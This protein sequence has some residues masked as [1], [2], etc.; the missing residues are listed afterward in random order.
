MRLLLLTL[1]LFLFNLTQNYS[2][3]KDSSCQNISV[4]SY[5][6]QGDFTAGITAGY[7]FK[8]QVPSYGL[9][10]D[11][12][13]HQLKIGLISIG[14]TGK[15]NSAVDENLDNATEIKTRNISAGITGKLNFNRLGIPAVIPFTGLVLGYNNSVTEY[16]INNN[17]GGY[18]PDT[19]KHSFYILGQ[20]GLQLFIS[21]NLAFNLTFSSG[22]IDKGMFEGGIFIKY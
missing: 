11:Y 3:L 4:N 2:Q 14:L 19:H 1:V 9:N 22:N 10:F 13:V 17:Y 20:A 7:S 8:S 15:Y 12:S 5:L 21:K 16:L 18:F 6:R